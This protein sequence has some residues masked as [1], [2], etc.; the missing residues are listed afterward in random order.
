MLFCSI[1]MGNTELPTQGPQ[2]YKCP[3]ATY[4]FGANVMTKKVNFDLFVY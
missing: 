1:V 2:V 4:E 3:L